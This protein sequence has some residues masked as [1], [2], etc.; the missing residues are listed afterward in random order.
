[1][2]NLTWV[3]KFDMAT[4]FL[5]NLMQK[6]KNLDVCYDFLLPPDDITDE[7]SIS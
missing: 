2:H 7:Q 1:M 4:S 3:K 6:G 5:M